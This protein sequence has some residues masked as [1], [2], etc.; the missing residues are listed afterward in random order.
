[1]ENMCY[2][3]YISKIIEEAYMKVQ[4]DLAIIDQLGEK[5]YA[6]L[7]PILAEYISNSYDADAN[8]VTIEVSLIQEKDLNNPESVYVYD[9]SIADDGCG[10]A[11]T[12]T[13]IEEIFLSFG[14][15]KRIKEGIGFSPIFSRPYHGKKGVGKLAG[16]GCAKKINI[17]TTRNNITNKFFL[18]YNKIQE[19]IENNSN[20]YYPEQEITD[21]NLGKTSGTKIIL[22]NVERLSKIDLSD[23]ALRLA[24]R[25]QIFNSDTS[26]N[27]YFKC[28]V[29]D[30][31]NEII[32]DNQMYYEFYLS[33]VEQEFTW[34]YDD[35]KDILTDEEKIFFETSEI[36]IEIN[37]SKTPLKR[38]NGLTIYCRKKLAADREFFQER[39]NDQFHSY[40]Y[41]KI[42]ADF[43]DEDNNKD[44]IS[45]ERVKINWE[46]VNPMFVAGMEKIIRFVQKVWREKRAENF[47]VVIDEYRKTENSNYDNLNPAEQQL[48]DTF[49]TQLTLNTNLTEEKIKEYTSYVEDMFEF[50][51]FQTVTK[52]IMDEQLDLSDSID[53]IRKWDLIEGKE[54][55]KISTG[56]IQAL[57]V[58]EQMIV[59]KE[60]ETKK[61]QP[62]LEKWPWLLD[63]SI[64]NF[65]REVT[66]ETALKSAF[67][68][69]ELDDTEVNRRLDFYCVQDKSGEYVIIELK[70]PGIIIT[71]EILDQVNEY[72]EY[73]K[74]LLEKEGKLRQAMVKTIL[75]MEPKLK[76][77]T[78]PQFYSTDNK[79]AAMKAA[80]V[81]SGK[82]ILKTYSQLIAVAK[83]NNKE[84]IEIYKKFNDDKKES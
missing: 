78:L 67:P 34:N 75:V 18:D 81:D 52:K 63:A 65:N 43:I 10:I 17:E 47:Q 37:T 25:L 20:D 8:N 42:E 70:R 35:V 9:I 14:R 49:L 6:Q 55:A 32:L 76:D 11:E 2:N 80:V 28:V 1:M 41:G 5:L 39:H 4:F 40:L 27:D 58:F 24:A 69:N 30:N 59:N 74:G 38:N 82:I 16:F 50:S 57:E 15:K 45:T 51:S 44:F 23:L 66:Y 26:L 61:I 73:I 13:Q 77:G 71:K 79:T 31:D 54:F 21:A 22:H 60:S 56:R 29:K 12:S 64:T 7:P 19:L 36:K 3:N 46:K 72:S 48:C 62:F 53:Y 68:N 33:D 84:I 83:E